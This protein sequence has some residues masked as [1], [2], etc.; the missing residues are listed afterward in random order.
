M[1][2]QSRLYD[3][4]TPADGYICRV[5]GSLK[6]VFDAEGDAHVPAAAARPHRVSTPQGV[7][8]DCQCQ[9]ARYGAHGRRHPK[10][11]GAITRAAADRPRPRA[12]TDALGGWPCGVATAGAE[13][14]PR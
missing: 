8:S 13:H 2:L 12:D 3:A 1:S 5:A 9:T 4:G 14:I 10:V 6:G 7:S 11:A